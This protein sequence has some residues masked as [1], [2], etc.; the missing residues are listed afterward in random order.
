MLVDGLPAGDFLGGHVAEL[1]VGEEFFEVGSADDGFPERHGGD[2]GGAGVA[3]EFYDGVELG[4]ID[5]GGVGAEVF[6]VAVEVVDGF[7]AALEGVHEADLGGDVAGETDADLIGGLGHGVVDVAF[8]AG[9]NFEEVPALGL[10]LAD[11][12]LGGGGEADGGGAVAGEAGAG[13]VERGTGDGAGFDLIAEFELAGPAEHAT[14]GG[15]AVGDEEK[16]DLLD[17]DLGGAER[18]AVAV[19][20]AEA[21]DK[22][23]AGAVDALGV[24]GDFYGGGGAD[25]DDAVAGDEDGLVGKDELGVHGHDGD[26]YEG[27]GDG[28]GCAEGGGEREQ[29]EQAEGGFHR[30]RG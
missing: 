29:A 18:R 25:V 6:D 20:L 1:G 24:G 9:V 19:H 28:S 16:V 2:D 3:R 26:V 8:Q 5:G 14:D 30:G 11:A 17:V 22:E 4:G 27:G 12:G 10:L 13:E 15:D 23:L 21:G 7:L